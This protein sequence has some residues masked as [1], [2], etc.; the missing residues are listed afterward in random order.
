MSGKQIPW[1]A[2]VRLHPRVFGC[3]SGGWIRTTDLRVMSPTSCHCSTPR[4]FRTEDRGLSTEPDNRLLSPQSSSPHWNGAPTYSPSGH[5]A[6][7]F[8][9][10]ALHDPVRDGSGWSHGA[11]THATGSGASADRQY[12]QARSVSPSH[13]TSSPREA[14]VHALRSP[15]RVTT[16]PAPAALP[17]ISGGT[18]LS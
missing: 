12:L 7:P 10:S 9:A 13:R 5:S 2:T 1:N 11:R 18:Y 4:R 14:L 16:P 6:T 3:G 17:V 8:R 15:P